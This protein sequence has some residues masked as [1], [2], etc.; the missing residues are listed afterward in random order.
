MASADPIVNMPRSHVRLLLIMRV[1]P[2]PAPA[3]WR[4]VA[5]RYTS[6]V[7]TRNGT[8][9]ELT[10]YRWRRWDAGLS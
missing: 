9:C 6:P 10:Y 1:L 3:K 8:A 5:P 4:N 7:P 2:S